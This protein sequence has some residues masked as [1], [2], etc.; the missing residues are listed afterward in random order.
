MILFIL[1]FTALFLG[2]CYS[3]GGANTDI[4]EEFNSFSEISNAKQASIKRDSM[5]SN[6]L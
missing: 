4:P 6:I 1:G 2:I 5:L 3:L